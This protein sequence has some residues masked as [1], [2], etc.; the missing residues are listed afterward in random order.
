MK[1]LSDTHVFENKLK[2]VCTGSFAFTGHSWNELLLILCIHGPF[3]H[4]KTRHQIWESQDQSTLEWRTRRSRLQGAA[5]CKALCLTAAILVRQ[6]HFSQ[7][8][9]MPTSVKR[10][11]ALFSVLKLATSVLIPLFFAR[12]LAPV[13]LVKNGHIAQRLC[14]PKTNKKLDFNS[15]NAVI[16]QRGCSSKVWN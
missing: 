4:W 1:Q 7:T 10:W 9:R 2:Y 16:G 14:L 3:R 11:A 15:S 6:Q 8:C 5:H 13:M 12:T